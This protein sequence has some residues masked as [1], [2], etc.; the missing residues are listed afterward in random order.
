MKIARNQIL[1]PISILGSVAAKT[2]SVP[3]L[4][5]VLFVASEGTNEIVMIASDSEMQFKFRLGCTALEGWKNASLGGKKLNDVIRSMPD[6]SE[7]SFSTMGEDQKSVVKSGKS[8]FTLRGFEH[9]DF[10]VMHFEEKDAATFSIKESDLKRLIKLVV[11]CIGV[12]DVRSYLNGAYFE[13]R[14]GK[15]SLVGTDGHRLAV[16]NVEIED[17]ALTCGAIIYKKMLLEISKVLGD[18]DNLVTISITSN[19]AKFEIGNVEVITRLI[20]GKFPDYTRVIPDTTNFAIQ[21]VGKT[22]DFR[23]A[24]SRVNFITDKVSNVLLDTSTPE[25]LLV[26]S[27]A[28]T[29]PTPIDDVQDVIEC[30][31]QIK[32]KGSK[33]LFNN[34]YMGEM[35]NIITTDEVKIMMNDPGTAAVI[36]F[37]DSKCEIENRFRSVVM[38]MRQ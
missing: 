8:K 2:N 33:C 26:T 27:E 10:P 7:I 25:G 29:G 12:N 16:S 24:F 4:E 9:K 35:M 28:V 20:E 19:M 14:D 22:E 15:F 13:V 34:T 17:K 30:D 1:K 18:G 21:I 31:M 6:D 23:K 37:H 11:P 38:P 36:M 3:V 5:S 32:D